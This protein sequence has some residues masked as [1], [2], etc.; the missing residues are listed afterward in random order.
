MGHIQFSTLPST[1]PWKRFTRLLDDAKL[2]P[3]LLASSL[4]AIARDRLAELRTDPSLTSCLWL[5]LRLVSAA[6]QPDFDK[7][8]TQ[9]GLDPR[10]ATTLVGLL[11]QVS[12]WLREEV[13]RYPESGPFG[14]LASLALRETLLDALSTKQRSLF[15]EPPFIAEQALRRYGT[16]VQLGQVVGRFFGC[17][18]DRVLKYYVDKALPLHIGPDSG[19]PTI[20][21]SELF[22]A[23]LSVYATSLSS[24]LAEFAGGWFSL[25]HWTANGQISREETTG[26]VAH[27]IEKLQEAM[28]A[29]EVHA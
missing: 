8:L 28:T 4:E 16:P 26:L 10:R 22:L 27:A 3:P 17:F 29:E 15:E 6:R 13:E 7:A 24:G 18:L 1:P 25:H 20:G 14:E 5:L 9:L 23:D 12:H 11:S 19:F 21:A 2:S